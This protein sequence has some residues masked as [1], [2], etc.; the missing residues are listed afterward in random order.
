MAWCSYSTL[1]L[2]VLLGRREPPTKR[3]RVIDGFLLG[4][5]LGLLFYDKITLF[6]AG[7]VAVGLG[8]ALSTLPRSPRLGVAALAGFAVVGVVMWLAFGMHST[9]YS[10]DL[11]EAAKVQ[12][13][14]A[15]T[16]MRLI[17]SSGLRRSPS[18]R[19]S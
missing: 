17:R 10:K 19:S 7:L 6:L 5:M 12:G 16:G 11:L 8:L 13:A 4:L 18:W 15:A 9:A 14:C 3:S 2:L 1:L